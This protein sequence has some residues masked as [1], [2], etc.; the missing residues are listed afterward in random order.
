MSPML[1]PAHALRGFCLSFCG[2]VFV[3]ANSVG[4]A[5]AQSS[6]LRSELHGPPSGFVQRAQVKAGAVVAE[7]AHSATKVSLFERYNGWQVVCFGWPQN[8]CE[9][10]QKRVRP[11]D[12]KLSLWLEIS[13][14][15]SDRNSVVKILVP[16]GGNVQ[17]PL[18]LSVD[19][20]FSLTVPFSTC[21]SV[22]C[23]A[24]VAA[25]QRLLDSLSIGSQLKVTYRELNG[26]LNSQSVLIDGFAEGY[27]RLAGAL[28]SR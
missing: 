11:N 6:F 4:A 7:P 10:S 28:R 16:L 5:T 23:V 8:R 22:G 12:Q 14:N 18:G 17:V 3:C 15:R 27:I 20:R 9:M 13:R 24:E 25:P 19:D 26:S 1:S 2:L 21:L